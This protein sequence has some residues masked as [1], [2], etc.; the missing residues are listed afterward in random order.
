MLTIEKSASFCRNRFGTD[1]HAYSLHKHAK[2]YE[3]KLRRLRRL[4]GSGGSRSAKELARDI[5]TSHSAMVTALVRS[6]KHPQELRSYYEL[7]DTAY[8]LD[9]CQDCEEPI[10]VIPT[11]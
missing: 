5:F 6:I 2:A 3:K 9:V 1:D 4:A 10:R 7:L 11:A 8:S